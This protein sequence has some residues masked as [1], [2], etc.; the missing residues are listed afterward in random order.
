MHSAGIN[1][2]KKTPL[3]KFT[4]LPVGDLYYAHVKTGSLTGSDFSISFHEHGT[5][6]QIT[7]NSK[8]GLAETLEEIASL[9]GQ[10]A[11]VQPPPFTTKAGLPPCD[12][13]EVI[14][15]MA[16]LSEWLKKIHQDNRAI[17][18][19]SA[20]R[21]RRWADKSQSLT[22]RPATEDNKHSLR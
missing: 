14:K 3:S 13:G 15:H 18:Q 19:S 21:P 9:I 6:Q 1:C 7:L 8:A 11:P 4:T 17:E 20:K 12:T 22:L 2:D 16:L 5:L 10:G